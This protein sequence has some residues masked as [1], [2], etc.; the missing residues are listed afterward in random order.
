MPWDVNIIR[1]KNYLRT[2]NISNVSITFNPLISQEGNHYQYITFMSYDNQMIIVF[3][4]RHKIPCRHR[5]F[6]HTSVHSLDHIIIIQ[7]TLQV[8]IFMH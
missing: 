6:Y 4:E 8:F 3:S 5:K 2:I 7:F 1:I